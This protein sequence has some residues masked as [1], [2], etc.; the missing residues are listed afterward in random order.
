MC[1][2]SDLINCNLY[3]QRNNHNNN[4]LLIYVAKCAISVFSH[5]HMM[6]GV[7]SASVGMRGVFLRGPWPPKAFCQFVK[8]VKLSSF[9]R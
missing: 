2:C 1:L 6:M 9:I 4:L 7:V 3:D 5:E 8:F